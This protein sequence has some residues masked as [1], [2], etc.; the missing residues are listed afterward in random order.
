MLKQTQQNTLWVDLTMLINW[1]GQ[2]TG[3]QRVEYNLAKRYAQESNVRFCYFDKVRRAIFECAFSQVEVKISNLQDHN[4]VPAATSSHLLKRI[5]VRAVPA[6][7]KQPIKTLIRRSK[8]ISAPRATEKPVLFGSGDTL[9]ILSGDWSDDTFA[10]LVTE[11]KN[12]QAFRV[13]QVIYDMLPATQPA[14]FVP[15]MPE[16][17]S[18]YMTKILGLS[19]TIL[20]ISKATRGDILNFQKI[21]GLPPAPVAVFRLGDDFMK[22]EPTKPKLDIASGEFILCVGTIEARKNHTLLYYV[23]KEAMRLNK[24]IPSIVVAGKRGWLVNDFLY[25][26][27]NDPQLKNK[28]IFLHDATDQELA[29]LFQNCTFSVYPSLYEGWGLPVAESLFYGKFCLASDSSSIPEVAGDLLDYFSP[30]DARAL[31]DL[32]I[33]YSQNPKLLKEKQASIEKGY[34]PTSWDDTYEEVKKIIKDI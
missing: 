26:V 21:H 15:G 34:R 11:L 18:R 31:L 23:V 32:I 4:P 3:I 6:P 2:L 1:Q 24:A 5:A 7:A 29:W 9:L 28:I 33:K 17:F 13:A 25:L 8:N 19:D 14:F 22:R 12:K 30:H 10:D 16:Q 20:A 27:E